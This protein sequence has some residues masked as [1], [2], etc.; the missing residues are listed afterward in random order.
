MSDAKCN[1]ENK[2]ESQSLALH[3]C[4]SNQSSTSAHECSGKK[5][6]HDGT[7]KVIHHTHAR[8]HDETEARMGHRDGEGKD[9]EALTDAEDPQDPVQR[10][11][12]H[13]NWLAIRRWRCT[14]RHRIS[15]PACLPDSPH[16]LSE[17]D[18]EEGLIHEVQLRRPFPLLTGKARPLTQDW[19]WR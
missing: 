13:P 6:A 10:C 19:T 16:R 5:E 3:S 17:V 2:R 9:E 11:W 18:L 12:R 15:R 8:T 4:H 14:Q 7:E 1:N